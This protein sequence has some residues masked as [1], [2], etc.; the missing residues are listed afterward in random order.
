MAIKRYGAKKA[1]TIAN[2][3]KG[4]LTT[5]GTGS[6]MG[7]ADI[8]EV[9]SIYGQ[10]VVGGGDANSNDGTQ[11][12]S[13]LLLQFPISGSSAGEIK[14]DRTAGTI[15]ASGS[16]NF[17]LRLH[18]AKHSQTVPRDAR[19]IVQAVSQSWNEGTGLDME[20]YKDKGITNWLTRST[21][22]GWQF[23]G[24]SYHT[25]SY[26]TKTNKAKWALT[27]PTYEAYLPIGTED[28]EV[29]ITSM[30]EEWIKGTQQNYGLGVRLTSSQEAFFSQSVGPPH[31]A[32]VDPGKSH[33]QWSNRQGVVQ[34]PSGSKES[35]YTKK[36]FSN[37][38]QFFFKQPVI[39][40]RWDSSTKDRRANFTY[41]SSLASTSDNLQTLYLYNFINGQLQNI[42]GI[43]RGPIYV[44]FFS[45]SGPAGD[46]DPTG[47]HILAATGTMRPDAPKKFYVTGGHYETGIYTAS[48]CLTASAVNH[49]TTIFDVWCSSSNANLNANTEYFTGSFNPEKIQA[50]AINRTPEYVTKI[51]NLK[52]SY[53]DN[54]NPKLRLF[55]RSKNWS[56]NIYTIASAD[57]D[58]SVVE[59]AYYRVFRLYDNQEIVQYGTGS[60][61]LDFTRLSYDVSGNYF[62][63]DLSL[64]KPD[65]MYGIKFSYYINGAYKEQPELFKFRIEKH[66]E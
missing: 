14:A 61:N 42:P 63:L 4:N 40:A 56:P 58:T 22:R 13:R 34:N 55:I 66:K 23:A 31:N 21:G 48:V 19:Y 47:T 50:S 32:G 8:L 7:K 5:R 64:F 29:D 53:T 43:W 10:S 20:E 49:L 11:E 27:M 1:T 25:A 26:R 3:F 28:L 16:V 18:N 59:D 33:E 65:G 38:T 41:S 24:G 60:S 35:F 51:T 39:E 46:Q 44:H 45:G 6:N 36:F 2:A 52:S 30:V 9:F 54:E 62:D 57:I 12:L 17:Y 15:P 37:G